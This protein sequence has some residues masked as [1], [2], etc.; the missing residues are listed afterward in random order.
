MNN[1]KITR[2]NGN[3]P[4]SLKGTD[5]ISGFLYYL[6]TDEYPSGFTTDHIHLISSI[7]SAEA[8]GIVSTSEVWNIQNLHYQ[9]SEVFRV[10]AGVSLYVGLFK[11]AAS[12]PTFTEVKQMQNFA[13]GEIKQLAVWNGSA[14]VLANDMATLQGVAAKLETESTPL[15]ILYAP[16]CVT[17]ASMPSDLIGSKKKNVSVVIGQDGD[18]IAHKLFKD[19]KAAG[20]SVSCI[21]LILGLVSKA[22]VHESIAWVGKFPTGINKPAFGDGTMVRSLDQSILDSLDSHRYIFLRTFPG[23]N[24]SF[25]NDS[26]NLDEK[27]SDYS[28]IE[29][30]RTMDKAVRG[31]RIYL[32]PELGRPLDVDPETGQLASTTV[33]HLENVASKQLEDMENAGE[34]SGYSVSIDP[35]QNVLT[36]S[37]IEFV[38]KNVAKGVMRNGEVKIGYSTSI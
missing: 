11:K 8:L 4:K 24:G 19:S 30:V 28:Q 35:N 27:T 10:N 9:L 22:K 3:I 37:T 16:K 18:G 13:N 1:I 36:T 31:I 7:E 29:L 25:V 26:H 21:G 14:P 2:E 33:K 38:I 6:G 15:S 23:I 20:S 17:P 34:L 12:T 32:L 5:H